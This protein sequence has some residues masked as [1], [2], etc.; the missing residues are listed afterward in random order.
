MYIYIYYYY[1]HIYISYCMIAV[2]LCMVYIVCVCMYNY[3]FCANTSII[4]FHM[5]QMQI[6]CIH[7]IFGLYLKNIYVLQF[8][9]V[10]PSQSP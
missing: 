5:V 2:C 7:D 3:I 8:H 4:Y 9:F 6:L 1:I 10:P